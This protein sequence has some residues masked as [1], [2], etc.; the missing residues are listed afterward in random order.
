MPPGRKHHAGTKQRVTLVGGVVNLLLGLGKVVAGYWG[1]SQSLIADGIHSLSDLIS[2]AVVLAAARIGSH[3]PDR[4]HPYGHA[5]IE[6]AATVGVGAILLAVAAGFI[7]HAGQR[8]LEPDTLWQPGWLAMIAA[9]VSVG[10]KEALFH[11]TRRA[12]RNA[13]S[14]LLD[15]NAWHHRSDALS[16][17]VVIIGVGGAMLGLPWLDAVAA[18]VVAAMIAR[19]GWQF[20]IDGLSELVDTGVEEERLVAMERLIRSVEGV[21][22]HH[23]LRTRRMGGE[24]LVDVHVEV[25]PDISITEAHQIG[26]RVRHRLLEALDDVS[27]VLVHV[28]PDTP[29]EEL[30]PRLP[31]RSRVL[32]DLEPFLRRTR[33]DRRRLQILLHY[34]ENR[35]DVDIMAPPGTDTDN[36]R[37]ILSP[38]PDSLSWLG[39]IRVLQTTE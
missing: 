27:D 29:H 31:S 7:L 8:M 3:G 14:A 5:R 17:I 13:H 10:A 38:A 36:A 4:N 37:H 32:H 34:G 6:T 19:M 26:E 33:L 24:V 22:G 11:Y 12:A 20:C 30:E 35:I 23:G 16:S 18:I 2:D 1:Q 39:N 21:R 9:L 15:A 25:A 28:D